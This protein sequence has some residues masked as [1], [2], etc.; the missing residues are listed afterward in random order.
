MRPGR[1]SGAGR[2]TL[3]RWCLLKDPAYGG[4]R[5]GGRD[6]ASTPPAP[7]RSLPAR[8]ICV[9]SPRS[10]CMWPTVSQ[11]PTGPRLHVTADASLTPPAWSINEGARSG[12][13]IEAHW[14][15]GA[16][17]GPR[18]VYTPSEPSGSQR[19]PAVHRSRR[20][21]VRSWET[22]PAENPDKD[23]VASRSACLFCLFPKSSAPPAQPGA[24]KGSLLRRVPL[25][26]IP[27]GAGTVNGSCGEDVWV[28]RR[29]LV[30]G[31]RPSAR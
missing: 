2:P 13:L 14:G 8:A 21:Q 15:P 20:W 29:F 30:V 6:S 31:G 9:P 26:V 22:S 11:T 4:E 16:R 25:C 23:E 12:R 27:E 18:L 19:S 3:G 24:L 10:S 1:K 28:L 5:A 7:G 17:P